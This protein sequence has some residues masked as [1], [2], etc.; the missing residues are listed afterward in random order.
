MDAIGAAIIIFTVI[1]IPII[2]ITIL[3][4]KDKY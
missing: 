4:C 3:K 1:G 2:C